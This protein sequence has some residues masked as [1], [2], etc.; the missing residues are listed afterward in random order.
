MRIGRVEGQVWGGR[1]AAGLDGVRLLQVRPVLARLRKGAAEGGP[2]G[3][4]DGQRDL[5]LSSTL[6]VAVDVLGAGVGE[7]VI[8]G[9]GSRVRDLTVGER[10]TTKLVVLGILDRAEIAEASP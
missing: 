2:A 3:L 8:Y 5:R 1:Q 4:A 6:V 7:Y 9:I 10:V